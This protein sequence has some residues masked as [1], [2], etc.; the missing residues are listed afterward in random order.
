MVY[1]PELD[2]RLYAVAI[3]SDNSLFILLEER[4]LIKLHSYLL[5]RNRGLA[6]K[7]GALLRDVGKKYGVNGNFED[8]AGT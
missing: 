3:K 1:V 7:F 6:D 5:V 2:G 8:E 4:E